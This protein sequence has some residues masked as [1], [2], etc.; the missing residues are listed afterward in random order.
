MHSILDALDHHK[1]RLLAIIESE[2][3]TPDDKSDALMR[4]ASLTS[5][6]TGM[7]I[8]RHQMSLRTVTARP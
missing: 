2:E 4:L 6:L 7:A 3:T 1:D 8:E 5:A